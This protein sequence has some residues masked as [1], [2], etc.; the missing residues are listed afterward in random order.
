MLRTV[1][2]ALIIA[3]GIMA[4]VGILT[5]INGIESSLR[6]QFA[7][8]GA[9]TFTIR[10]TGPNI[11]IGRGGKKPKVHPKIPFHQAQ[12]FKERFSGNTA[13]VSVSYIASGI[14]QV[15]YR[16][17][18]TDPNIQVWA[19]DEHFLQ[20]SGY[21]LE[22]GRNFSI[23][24]VKDAAPV[25]IIGQTV[26]D[27]LFPKEDPIGKLIQIRNARYRIVG[28]TAEKGN[29][30]GSGGDKSVFIP[31]QK[32]RSS[33][34]NNSGTFALNVMALNGAVIDDVVG[35]ATMAMRAVRKLKPRQ[36]SNF[37]ITKSDNLSQSLI[38]NLYYL[39]ITAVIIGAITLFGAAVALMNIMLVSVTERTRE[40][41]IRKSVGAKAGTIM[42]QFLLEAVLICIFGGVAGIIF[43]ISIGN[44][45]ALFFGSGF[46][47][48]WPIMAMAVGLCLLVGVVSGFYPSFKAARLD[49]IESLRYE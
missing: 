45:V 41:G 18:K 13:V 7:L 21:A 16:N 42:I 27:K 12:A 26:K 20:T 43:G 19:A 25:A 15:K 10:N 36:E 17:R 4:L 9:N 39:R 29:S 3:F 24:E 23:A 8:L 6:G 37:D 5:A 30:F 40:I 31:I 35:E 49:P 2:T 38:E 48:Q 1:I 22:K 44:F 11:Q 34:G 33:F 46:V 32:A 47:I 28:L 14:A